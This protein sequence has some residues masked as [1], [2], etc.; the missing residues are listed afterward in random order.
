MSSSI[1]LRRSPKPGAFTAAT[2][3]RAA[4]LVDDE[5]GQRLALDVLGDDEE[6]LA[7]PRDLLQDGKQILHRR[8]LLLVDE[9]HRVLEHDLHAF[10]IG[11]EIRREIPA[12][13]L[14]ALDDIE[15]RLER[16]RLLQP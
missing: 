9:D 8:D 1:A 14:H 12:V 15:R 7:E 6:R 2:L 16:L 10:G 5:R 4:Q 13:E 11:H 3:Q